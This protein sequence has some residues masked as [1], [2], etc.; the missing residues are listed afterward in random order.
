MKQQ[1]IT[2]Y[3]VTA[4][5]VAETRQGHFSRT[6]ASYK[7]FTNPDLLVTV[8]KDASPHVAGAILAQKSM[9]FPFWESFLLT[10]E[11]GMRLKPRKGAGK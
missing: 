7:L 4:Y 1:D 6:V 8:P 3:L 9:Q 2:G 11:I 5:I 10:W